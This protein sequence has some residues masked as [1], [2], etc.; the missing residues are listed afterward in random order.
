M[1]LGSW[2]TSHYNHC[3]SLFIQCGSSDSLNWAEWK[4]ID[5]LQ[6]RNKQKGLRLNSEA[7][8][9]KRFLDYSQFFSSSLSIRPFSFYLV[10]RGYCIGVRRVC[11]HTCVPVWPGKDLGHKITHSVGTEAASCGEQ[12][13]KNMSQYQSSKFSF[14]KE[15][16]IKFSNVF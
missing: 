11:E 12:L 2:E 6:P 13:E 7:S 1:G 4:S 8:H 10:N 14:Y 5:T 16:G 9:Y 15:L 3:Q